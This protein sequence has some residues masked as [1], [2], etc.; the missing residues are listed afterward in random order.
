T[1][2]YRYALINQD[3]GRIDDALAAATESVAVVEE[4]RAR[5]VPRDFL[6]RGYSE[7]RQE[8][9]GLTIALLYKK[10]QYEQALGVREK[11]RARA[12]LDLL[13]SRDAE[14]A[15]APA[16]QAGTQVDPNGLASESTAR[17]ASASDIA[18]TAHRLN[19]AILSYWVSD[20][21]TYIWVVRE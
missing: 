17:P 2:L 4:I 6:K 21:E 1:L 3:L 13:A 9:F 11:A 12:F 14:P 10:G 20:D 15:A 8:R 5:L 19:S 7:T 16:A 18:E